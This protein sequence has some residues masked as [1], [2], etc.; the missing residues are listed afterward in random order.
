[1]NKFLIVIYYGYS[2]NDFTF[3]KDVAINLGLT[4]NLSVD[5][6]SGPLGGQFLEV[7]IDWDNSGT[8]E[9]SNSKGANEKVLTDNIDLS[10][11]GSPS[12]SITPPASAELNTL[13]RMRVV[14]EFGAEPNLCGAG[15]GQRADD[16]GVYVKP[17]CTDFPN[18]GITNNSE[19]TVVSCE[20][21]LI[22]L[23]ATGGDYYFWSNNLGNNASVVITEPGT[24]NVIVMSENGC[25]DT[26]TITIGYEKT[27]VV[28]DVTSLN[29]N[30]YFYCGVT[31]VSFNTIFKN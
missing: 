31:N 24:Y 13:L 19:S 15:T 22:S 1:M 23:T 25:S 6:I 21:P 3:Y 2:L 30:D 4:Y 26:E 20:T 29:S 18:A 11:A 14:S 16:Y 9:T 5:Y 12:A 7:W 28:C 27:A 10:S 17:A 8:F